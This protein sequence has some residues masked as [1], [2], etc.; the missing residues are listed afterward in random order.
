M[1]KSI[2]FIAFISVTVLS[3]FAQTNSGFELPYISSKDIIIKHPGYTLSFN[4]KHEQA[5]WVDYELTAEETQ[6]GV[7]RTNR[8][9]PDN[10]VKSGSTVKQIIRVRGMIGVIWHPQPI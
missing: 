10:A 8:F 5:N 1:K 6:K 3:L 4:K 9:R 2:L 7:E